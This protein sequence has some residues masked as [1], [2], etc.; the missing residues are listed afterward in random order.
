MNFLLLVN[1]NFTNIFGMICTPIVSFSS[2]GGNDNECFEKKK[3][4]YRFRK[5]IT[6]KIRIKIIEVIAMTFSQEILGLIRNLYPARN[7]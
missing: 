5:I 4:F 2:D 1:I 3:N 6:N 7:T